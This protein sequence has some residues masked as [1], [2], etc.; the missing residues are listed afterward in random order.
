MAGGG[1]QLG[2]AAGRIQGMARELTDTAE[3]AGQL[4]M[5]A[6]STIT[7]R[8]V[9]MAQAMSDPV[10]AMSNPEFTRM[11]VE[12]VE[13]AVE[14][15]RALTEGFQDLGL[16]W[17]ELMAGQMQLASEAATGLQRCRTPTD[18]MALQSQSFSR[19]MTAGMAAGL[20]FAESATALMGA[21]LNPMHRTASANARRLAA[22]A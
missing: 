11:G 21:G 4:G 15:T 5:A 16:A 2:S 9:M 10:A 8:A 14:A 12:K 6:A 13:A 7:H 22:R 20:R 3:K 1:S 18:F 17:W 19:C